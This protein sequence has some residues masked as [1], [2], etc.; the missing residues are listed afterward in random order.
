MKPLALALVLVAALPAAAELEVL[1]RERSLYQT[2]LITREPGRLCLR[3][4][5]RR[6]QRNQSCMNPRQP[7]RMVFTYTRMMT[8]ALLL[9]PA[10]SRVLMAGLGGGTLPTALAELL[11][12]T[13]IDAVEVDAAVVAAA[14]KYFDFRESDRLRVVVSDAR[15]FVK[16]ALRRGDRYDLVLLDAYGGD[17]IPEHLMTVEFLEETR[18]LLTPGGV[19]AANTFANSRLYDHESE[20][21]RAVFG[22][23]FNLKTPTSANRIV[24]AANGP[25]PPKPVL[26]DNARA[27]RASLERYGVPI[28]DYPNRLSLDV[29]WDVGKRPLTDQYAPANLLQD[30]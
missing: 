21:Y 6:E 18:R 7:R 15:V 26:R 1:H 27:W 10:P 4:S 8:A 28:D 25:L 16:R 9:Q 30:R 22:I 13:H 29:D 19:V 11:P 3:F 14:R 5:V 12:N 2:L 20:T 24:L 17:Y 23:F